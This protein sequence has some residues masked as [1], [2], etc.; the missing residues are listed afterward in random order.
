MSEKEGEAV[1]REAQRR[2]QR[3][4]GEGSPVAQGVKDSVVTAGVRV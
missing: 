1:H 3:R 4:S 2:D